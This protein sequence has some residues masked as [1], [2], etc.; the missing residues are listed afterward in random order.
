MVEP[1]VWAAV[2]ALLSWAFFRTRWEKEQ[3]ASKEAGRTEQQREEQPAEPEWT[4]DIKRA[5]QAIDEGWDQVWERQKERETA[6]AAVRDKLRRAREVIEELELQWTLRDLWRELRDGDLSVC[7]SEAAR[8]FKNLER[9][10]LTFSHRK[11]TWEWADMPFEL[12]GDES[13]HEYRRLSLSLANEVLFAVT[14]SMDTSSDWWKVEALKVGPWMAEAI[15]MQALLAVESDAFMSG[16]MDE[17]DEEIAARIS[18][19]DRT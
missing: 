1:L 8:R 18:F 12:E 17:D 11:I 2:G 16:I 6:T 3:A 5:K 19:D 14:Y 9:H 7:T 15:K 10:D 4:D 13:D